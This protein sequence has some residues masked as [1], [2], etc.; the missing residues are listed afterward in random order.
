MMGSGRR[1]GADAMVNEAPFGRQKARERKA[2]LAEAFAGRFY[3]S[4]A[5]IPVAR[6]RATSK[7]AASRNVP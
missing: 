5:D 3:H 4:L 7:R 1:M 6:L 2:L